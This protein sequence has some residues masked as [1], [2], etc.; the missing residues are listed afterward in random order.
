[1]ARSTRQRPGPPADGPVRSYDRRMATDPAARTV[2]LLPSPLLPD[3]VH[4]GLRDALD[5]RG[6]GASVAPAGLDAGQG[7]LDLVRRWARLVGPGTVLV[8]HSNAGYLAPLVRAAGGATAPVV[9]MD[10]ALPPAA[11]SCA[12]APA[13]FRAWLGELADAEGQLPPWTRWWPRSDLDEVLPADLFAAV[14]AQCPRL[15]LDY[16][17]TVV[18][19]P[20]GWVERPNAYIAFG[21]TY[22][23]ERAVAV[24]HDWPVADLAGSHLAFV[25][26]PAVVATAIASLVERLGA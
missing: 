15:S 18:T 14:D 10:A 16:V 21:D 22:A 5:H 25:T 9:F 11:G 17:D 3:S 7:A 20:P 24:R 26:E 4:D 8:A 19:V 13:P 6:L 23:D 1:M 12:L 2:L